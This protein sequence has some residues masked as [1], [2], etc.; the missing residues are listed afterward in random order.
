MNPAQLLEH[1]NRISEAPDA[2]ARLRRF[3]LDLAVRGKLVEQDPNDEPAVELLKR[4]QV[5]RA[6]LV[7]EGKSKELKAALTT[8]TANSPYELP[9]TWQLVP[10]GVTV[11]SHLGG[12]T[13]SKNNSA[14][15]DGDIYWAS[16]KDIGKGKY[17]DETIDRITESGLVDSSSN[18]IPPGNLIVVTRMGLGKLSIN[19]VPIAIN[20]DLR[21]LLLSSLVSIDYYYNFFKTY[22]FEGSGLTVKGIRV[23][24][25]LNTPFPL[26]PLAEQHRIVAKVDELMAL[27]DQLEAAQSKREKQRDRLVAASLHHVGTALPESLPA[28]AHFHLDNLPRLTTRPEHI[29][30]LRQTILNLAVRGR[31]VPQDPNDEPIGTLV[32]RI[33]LEQRNLIESGILKNRVP[34][35]EQGKSGCLFPIPIEW[36]WVQL[37]NLI[38]FGPQNGVSPKEIKDDR[39]PKA[40]TLTATTSGL[41]NAAYYKH[42]ELPEGD[43][44]SYWLSPGDVLFQRGNTREYV[45]IAAIFDG[46]AKSF[47]FPDLMIRVRFSKSLE[48]RFAHLLLVSPPL[49]LYFSSKATGASATMPKIN[50]AVLLNAP[51]PLPPLAEQHRIV[52]KVDELMAL[53]DQLEAQLATSQTD[54]RRLLEAVLRDALV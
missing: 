6:R 20:Q 10:L 5:E 54:S 15:W 44:D 26:P 18:L 8:I 50:Q 28:A 3:V 43:C 47:I 19:R 49:R 12:G 23:E 37:A 45:G 14:Y 39:A 52:A 11:N 35:N 1:F 34:V 53:C 51:I 9:T 25:L 17:V 22:G 38:T 41:F 24:E 2:V 16:V 46:P 4:I 40:I 33:R 36:C 48:L 42:V 29:K 7:K 30:Q 32:E 13:P 21:A 31:L 27:C